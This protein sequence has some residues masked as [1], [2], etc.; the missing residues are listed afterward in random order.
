[1]DSQL[2]YSM[3][4]QWSDEDRAFIVSFPEWEAHG[5]IGNTHGDTYAQAI[6]NGQEV[7][8]M[9]IESARERGEPVPAPKT[10]AGVTQVG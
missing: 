1:M 3:V 8:K 7:L 2:H 10:Y 5:L 9:L 4:V 6:A